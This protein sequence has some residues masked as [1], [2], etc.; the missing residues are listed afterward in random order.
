MRWLGAPLFVG[1]VLVIGAGSAMLP[2]IAP[3]NMSFV[4]AVGVINGLAVGFAQPL[5]LTLLSDDVPATQLGSPM[6]CRPSPH[7]ATTTD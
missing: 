7:P 4:L 3:G 6:T 5:S 2:T 1:I